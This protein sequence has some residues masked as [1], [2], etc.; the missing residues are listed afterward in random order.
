M[1]APGPSAA[2]Q[3]ITSF[4]KTTS[5]GGL[6]H[7]SHRPCGAHESKASRV[8]PGAGTPLCTHRPWSS[9]PG[10]WSPT[11]AV[12]GSRES[13]LSVLVLLEQR[14]EARMRAEC[15]PFRPQELQKRRVVA[16]GVEV[17]VDV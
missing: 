10:A 12:N 16:Q 17:D 9:R 15:L 1:I 14:L 7:R 13:P 4:A 6:P 8:G 5:P 11:A 3:F 2:L